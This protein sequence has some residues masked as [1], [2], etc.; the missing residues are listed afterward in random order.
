MHVAAASPIAVRAEEVDPA[1]VARERAIFAEQARETGKP[2]SII[3][4]MVEGRIRKFFEEVVLLSQNFV[5]DAE[6]TVAQAV[7]AAE[8]EVGA[9]INVT[10][11][12][13]FRLGEGVEKEVTDFAAEVA[14]AAGT[15]KT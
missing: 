7:K 9:P 6:K 5:V 8:A 2:E 12:V 1:I 14:A 13:V 10:E 15:D 11:F 3:E 4:K